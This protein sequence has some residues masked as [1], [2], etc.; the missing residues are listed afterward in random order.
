MAMI[1]ISNKDIQSIGHSYMYALIRHENNVLHGNTYSSFSFVLYLKV[2]SATY[3][4]LP[5]DI[6]L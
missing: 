4:S 5:F 2:S 3:F 6:V 1:I